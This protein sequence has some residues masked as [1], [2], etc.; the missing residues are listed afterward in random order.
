MIDGS[1]TTNDRMAISQSAVWAKKRVQQELT[2]PQKN[3]GAHR[4]GNRRRDSFVAAGPG[5]A[6]KREKPA[7][8]TLKQPPGHDRARGRDEGRVC[9]VCTY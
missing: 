2:R 1:S 8:P 9:R 3:G 6:K 4:I 5:N 7:M